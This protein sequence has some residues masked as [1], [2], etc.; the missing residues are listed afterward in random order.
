MTDPKSR[1]L[2]IAPA[3]GQALARYYVEGR[4]ITAGNLAWLYEKL[5]GRT[6]SPQEI[7]QSRKRLAEAYRTLRAKDGEGETTDE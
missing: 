3:T 4:G 7:E 1:N 5:T 2:I 6:A